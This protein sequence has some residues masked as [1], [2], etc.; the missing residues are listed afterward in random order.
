MRAITFIA[1]V[2]M[3]P[4]R[5]HRAQNF[6]GRLDVINA[7]FARPRAEALSGAAFP[8]RIQRSSNSFTL[9]LTAFTLSLTASAPNATALPSARSCT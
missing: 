2:E 9:S 5:N 3:K 4:Q 7:R 1:V 8:H 6:H